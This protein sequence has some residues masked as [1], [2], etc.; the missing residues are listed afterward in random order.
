MCE[1][2]NTFVCVTV[3]NLAHGQPSRIKDTGHEKSPEPIPLICTR[4]FYFHFA[5]FVPLVFTSDSA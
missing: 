1:R 4:L 2:D 5:K 3:D